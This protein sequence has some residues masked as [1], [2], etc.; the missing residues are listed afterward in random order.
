MKIVAPS[1]WAE[2]E[3]SQQMMCRWAAAHHNSSGI[4]EDQTKY[5]V[6]QLLAY[7]R[8]SIDVIRWECERSLSWAMLAHA[9]PARL[10]QVTDKS[11][12]HWKAQLHLHILC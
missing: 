4:P 9:L 8:I 1:P 7:I 2:L 3:H 12:G 5:L 11:E 6:D 10:D